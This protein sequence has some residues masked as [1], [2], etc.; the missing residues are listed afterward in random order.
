MRM[1][2]TVIVVA[3]SALAVARPA[4]AQRAEFGLTAGYNRTEWVANSAAEATLGS[5]LEGRN[6][7]TIG[8]FA[9]LEVASV[10]AIQP[11]AL[12]TRRGTAF[13]ASGVV[14]GQDI[15]LDA[16]Y[17]TSYI[18]FP[19]LLRVSLPEPARVLPFLLAGPVVAAEWG[20]RVKGIATVDGD[21]GPFEV[22]SDA[23]GGTDVGVVVG[24]GAATAHDGGMI[25]FDV[26]YELG[27]R[28]VLEPTDGADAG[29][30]RGREAEK[31]TG[32]DEAGCAQG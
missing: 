29:T 23:F 1:C 24:G 22:E 30:R 28:S 15:T 8:A 2:T 9:A 3:A 32:T 18:Q 5:D 19:L 25:Y 12:Y 21:T 10:I 13:R 7:F 6:A 20:S 17:E 31:K 14:E 4:A 16:S 27:L 26:R 11:E